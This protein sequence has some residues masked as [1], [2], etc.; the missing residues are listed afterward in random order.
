VK[1]SR[2]V[3]I[4]LLLQVRGRMTAAQL[5][6]ELEVS[7]RTIYRDIESLHIAG[8]PLYADAGHSGGYRLLGGHRIRL[9]G[10]TETEVEALF[11]SIA[12]G[13]AAEL[14]LGPALAAAQLKLRAAFPRELTST[15]ERIRS[16]FLLDVPGWFDEDTEVPHLRQ[17]SEAVWR[18]RVLDIRYRRWNE[19][20]AAVRRV[21]PYGLVLKA[22]CW[23]V[24]AGPGPRTYRVDRIL[25]V[26]VCDEQFLIPP[27]FN[28]PAYW[29]STQA[30][31]RASR[32]RAAG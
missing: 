21:E 25:T 5:A 20:T 1:A 2:L 3:S 24:V 22:G 6:R 29:R 18:S 28:L 31:F 17:V 27:E 26:D 7:V 30:E 14:G 4:L 15:A 19:T 32:A 23:Y 13:P 10:L 8:V 12:P 16:R 9:T 11:L